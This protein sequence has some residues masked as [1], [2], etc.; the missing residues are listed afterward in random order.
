MAKGQKIKAA[1]RQQACKKLARVLKKRYQ[2]SLPEEKPVLETLLYAICLENTNNLQAQESYRR[3][4][5]EFFD[6]N[7]VRVSSISELATVFDG[8]PDPEKRALQVRNALHDIFEKNFSFDFEGLKKKTADLASK[9]LKRIRELSSFVRSYVLQ[10]SLD[11]HIVPVDESMKNAAIWLGF[12]N[13]E[14]RAEDVAD[15]LK[16]A[17][18]KSEAQLFCMLLKCLA[19]DRQLQFGFSE[20]NIRKANTDFDL[21]TL[22]ERLEELFKESKKRPRKKTVKKAVPQKKTGRKTTSRPVKKKAAKKPSAKKKKVAKKKTSKPK[23]KAVTK[24][25]KTKRPMK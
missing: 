6:L 16:P 1:D 4:H 23:K 2:V 22:T 7:E 14:S 8:S 25:K 15:F 11:S 17:L 12:A 3:L 24:R 9:Q 18:R 5:E 19:T 13:R 21:F 10:F 20:R